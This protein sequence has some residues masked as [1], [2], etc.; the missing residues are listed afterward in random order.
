[1]KNE[2]IFFAKRKSANFA[3]ALTTRWIVRPTP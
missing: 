1:M 3:N 2:F